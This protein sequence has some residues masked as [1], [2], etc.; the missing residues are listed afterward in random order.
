MLKM[1]TIVLSLSLILSTFAFS[2]SGALADNSTPTYSY[3]LELDEE[4]IGEISDDPSAPQTA[5]NSAIKVIRARIDATGQSAATVEA[6]EDRQIVIS[7]PFEHDRDELMDLLG[8]GTTLEFGVVGEEILPG[9]PLPSDL[10]AG[11]RILPMPDG[12]PSAKVRIIDGLDGSRIEEARAGFDARSDEA[13][14]NLSFDEEGKR[15]FGA[16]T[17]ANVD[18]KIAVIL[19]GKVI[20]VPIVREPIL[21]GHVQISGGFTYESANELA[22]MLRSGSLPV[23]I[24]LVEERVLN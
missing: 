6:N 22:I 21:G 18:K 8:I 15:L 1:R 9:D 12:L 16:F 2:A 17:A 23:P 5:L 19:D 13:V 20:T 14:V 11:T 10:P 7:I 3:V 4:A 24:T